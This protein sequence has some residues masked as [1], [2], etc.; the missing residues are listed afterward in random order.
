MLP[1]MKFV[2]AVSSKKAPLKADLQTMTELRYVPNQPVQPAHDVLTNHADYPHDYQ[3][4]YHSNFGAP[5]LEGAR[6]SLPRRQA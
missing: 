3:I 4:I 2:F 5:V 1:R 6:A